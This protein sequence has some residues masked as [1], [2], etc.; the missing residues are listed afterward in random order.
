MTN[1]YDFLNRTVLAQSFIWVQN[2]IDKRDGELPDICY[3]I[4]TAGYNSLHINRFSNEEAKLLEEI[5]TSEEFNPIRNTDISLVVMA[6]EVMRLWIEDVPKNKRPLININDKKLLRGKNEYLMYMLAVK[7]SNPDI[8]QE[9]KDIIETTSANAQ[10][11]YN[12]M[13]DKLAKGE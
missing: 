5:T 7:K 13:K 2:H 11:W 6:L 8:Y 9:Q 1:K 10:R 3:K 12:H 4:K